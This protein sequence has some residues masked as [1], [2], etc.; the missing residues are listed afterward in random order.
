MFQ[1]SAASWPQRMNGEI[2]KNFSIALALGVIAA[3]AAAQTDFTEPLKALSPK[4]KEFRALAVK[5]DY[6]GMRNIAYSYA[7]PAKGDTGSKVASCA[8]YLLI[9]AVHKQ[10]FGLG[11][12]GNIST[13]CARLSPDELNTAYEY[14]F[15]GLDASAK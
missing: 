5:G 11:D 1:S 3:S 9:P 8:W 13:Y 4:Q 10:K 2:M 12:T 14:A 15:R 7:A 6:Q